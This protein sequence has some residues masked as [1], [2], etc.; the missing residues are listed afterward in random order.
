ME[1]K[2]HIL[3]IGATNLKTGKCKYFNIYE[4]W[5]DGVVQFWRAK[6]SE[7]N[8]KA[9]GGARY[10]TKERWRV[11]FGH[12]D[13][14]KGDIVEFYHDQDNSYMGRWVFEKQVNMQS[15]KEFMNNPDLELKGNT[16]NAYVYK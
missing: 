7:W 6:T 3:P 8:N 11:V 15:L 5:D 1:N 10:E 13:N 14:T 12:A 16:I 2:A 9:V 4:T